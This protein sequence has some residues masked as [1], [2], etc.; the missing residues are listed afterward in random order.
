ML[1]IVHYVVLSHVFARTPAPFFTFQFPC[2]SPVNSIV[3][4]KISPDTLRVHE[5]PVTK[6]AHVLW[7]ITSPIC[8]CRH[9]VRHSPQSRLLDT[10]FESK[11]FLITSTTRTLQAPPCE[12]WS[13]SIDFWGEIEKGNSDWYYQLYCLYMWYYQLYMQALF[14]LY[15][16]PRHCKML[17]V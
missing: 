17:S 7:D 12:L 5:R 11:L 9:R 3:V 10:Q 2:V 4:S 13:K 8:H 6:L 14:V 15:F 1:S 16:L